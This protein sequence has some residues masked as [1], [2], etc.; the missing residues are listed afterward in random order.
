MNPQHEEQVFPS[1]PSRDEVPLQYRQSPDSPSRTVAAK[2]SAKNATF[3]QPLTATAAE[4]ASSDALADD[5]AAGAMQLD[6]SRGELQQKALNVGLEKEVNAH[7]HLMTKVDGTND[8][9]QI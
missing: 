7:R 3:Q 1:S 5:D 9:D 8:D 4:V 6:T 2:D